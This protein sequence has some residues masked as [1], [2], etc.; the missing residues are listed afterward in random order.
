[1]MDVIDHGI[2]PAR[3]LILG[4]ELVIRDT[5]GTKYR[6]MLSDKGNEEDIQG[7]LSI[8]NAVKQEV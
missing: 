8:I 4:T 6:G 2:K 1:L 7:A 3:Q 5:C